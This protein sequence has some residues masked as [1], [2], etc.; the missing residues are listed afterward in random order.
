MHQNIKKNKIKQQLSHCLK[1]QK[2]LS[3]DYKLTHKAVEIAMNGG[4]KELNDRHQK[5]GKMLPRHRVSKILDTES[6]FLEL[7][8]TPG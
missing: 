5:R 6:Y 7:G 4:G 1:N 8:L 2:Q 3:V